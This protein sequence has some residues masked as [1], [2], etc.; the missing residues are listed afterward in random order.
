LKVGTPP[1]PPPP[2]AIPSFN[3]SEKD[4]LAEGGAVMVSVTVGIAVDDEI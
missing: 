2:A 4:M 1:A 3:L